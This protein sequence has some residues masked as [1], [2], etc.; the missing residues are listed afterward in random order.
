AAP[1]PT[2]PRR[3]LRGFQ[4][5]TDSRSLCRHG[6]PVCAAARGLICAA[7]DTAL[8]LHGPAHGW[9]ARCLSGP[10]R[11]GHALDRTPRPASPHRPRG[12]HKEGTGAAALYP[13]HWF[14]SPP[15]PIMR[16]GRR[17]LPLLKVHA[18]A[19][20]VWRGLASTPGA[21]RPLTPASRNGLW[22]DGSLTA[23]L[24]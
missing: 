23:G 15:I 3:C 9:T 10:H 24:C 22:F 17:S 13:C 18:G 12:A 14:L 1:S 20:R 21:G 2:P 7:A 5:T 16:G 11:L 6:M 8:P 19:W 4:A